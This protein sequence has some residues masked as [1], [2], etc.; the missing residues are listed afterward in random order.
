M[1]RYRRRIFQIHPLINTL[2]RLVHSYAH[3]LIRLTD[4]FPSSG[5]P[6]SHLS[7]LFAISQCPGMEG[8]VARATQH[9]AFASARRRDLL[10]D[11]SLLHV[12]KLV[13]VMNFARRASRAAVF[14]LP[15]VE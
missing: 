12:L 11:R 1:L 3:R 15:G 9:D 2:L 8:L 6:H 5:S 14:A 7:I 13:G 4:R 10:P